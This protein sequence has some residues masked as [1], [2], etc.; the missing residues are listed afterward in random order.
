LCQDYEYLPQNSET[1]IYIAMIRL[2][3]RRLA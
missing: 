3:V 2:M 1:M